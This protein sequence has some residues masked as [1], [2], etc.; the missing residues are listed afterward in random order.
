MGGVDARILR[1]GP[2]GVV[3]MLTVQMVIKGVDARILQSRLAP[4]RAAETLA[5]QMMTKDVDARILHLGRLLA[6]VMHTVQMLTKD[7]DARIL[8]LAPLNVAE[9]LIETDDE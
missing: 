2:L 9:T 6:V 8:R 1:L 4:L 7:V 3:V 5:V